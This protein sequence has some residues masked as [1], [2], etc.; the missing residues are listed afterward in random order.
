MVNNNLTANTSEF[1]I[2]YNDSNHPQLTNEGKKIRDINEA[3]SKF[4][5]Y[6]LTKIGEIIN[7][8]LILKYILYDLIMAG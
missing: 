4:Y 7:D 2:N 5:V 1:G 6:E 8:N 3:V